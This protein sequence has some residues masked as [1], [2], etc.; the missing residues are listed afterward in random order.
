MAP[1]CVRL[2]LASEPAQLR[3]TGAHPGCP[4][5]S[6][7]TPGVG[8]GE[9]VWGVVGSLGVSKGVRPPQPYVQLEKFGAKRD[10]SAQRNQSAPGLSGRIHSHTRYGAAE[11]TWV[12]GG[13]PGGEQGGAPPS[14]LRA[15]TK[16][17]QILD[18]P[19]LRINSAHHVL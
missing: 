6:T 10:A 19:E 8:R 15:I 18:H 17:W 5:K 16:V 9:P 11:A 13:L 2:H 4:V 3:E 1:F 14:P 7:P 12:G